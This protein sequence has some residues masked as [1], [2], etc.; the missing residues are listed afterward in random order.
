[1]STATAVSVSREKLN[2]LYEAIG[3][4]GHEKWDNK[5]ALSKIAKLKDIKDK[6]LEE[7]DLT[8]PQRSLLEKLQEAAKAGTEVTI[9][10]VKETPKEETKTQKGE[11]KSEGEEKK[12]KKKGGFPQG[13]GGDGKP[14]VIAS[15][16]EFLSKASE[17]KPV[18]KK[19]IVKK[20]KE[21][22]PD[23]D[24]EAMGKTVNVQVPNRLRKD[25]GLDVK[26]NESGYWIDVMPAGKK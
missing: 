12:E 9:E 10:E 24:D 1:M 2:D 11:T 21:R 5:K 19:D 13:A 26:K 22:F 17:E 16:K 23:R 20:L 18:S 14:G 3:Y 6:D 25:A 8:K 4:T 7:V 15:I